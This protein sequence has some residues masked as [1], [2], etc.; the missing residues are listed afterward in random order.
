M[1]PRIRK[2]L[3]WRIRFHIL[4]A[5]TCGL[6]LFAFCVWHGINKSDTYYATELSVAW[7]LAL[8]GCYSAI[9]VL[10]RGHRKQRVA[11]VTAIAL[12]VSSMA[13]VSFLNHTPDPSVAPPRPLDSAE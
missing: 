8:L 5:C 13:T 4:S 1:A 3:R 7:G 9:Y 10:K 6:L 11:V 12:I 2:S